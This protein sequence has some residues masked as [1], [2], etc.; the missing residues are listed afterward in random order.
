MPGTNPVPIFGQTPST[1]ATMPSSSGGG[2]GTLQAVINGGLGVFQSVLG[3]K[4]MNN[5]I[6][7]NQYPS[8]SYNAQGEPVGVPS[9]G[10][11]GFGGGSFWLLI[12]GIVLLV[13]LLRK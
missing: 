11:A 13:L 12:I 1:P 8:I 10:L 3:Y 2:G 4:L 7:H 6:N 5:Q 9:V